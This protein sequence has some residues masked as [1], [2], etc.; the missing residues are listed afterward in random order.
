MT[1]STTQA[2][3]MNTIRAAGVQISTD[4]LSR[5]LPSIPF[6]TI[7]GSLTKLKNRGVVEKGSFG[8]RLPANTGLAR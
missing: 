6:N 5:Q 4:A 3:I 7:R 8:W 2:V 1:N